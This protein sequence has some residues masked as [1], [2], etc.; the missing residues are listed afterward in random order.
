MAKKPFQRA[1]SVGLSLAL[2]AGMVAPALAADFTDLQEAINDTTAT[3]G[4]EPTSNGTLISEENGGIYGYGWNEATKD[5]ESKGWDIWA[6]NDGDTRNVQLNED[7]IYDAA[8][9]NS[10][11]L[12]TITISNKKV[13]LDL[14]GN[15]IDGG[16][17]EEVKD[18]VGRV[19][20]EA[21]AG[22]GKSVI[23][24]EKNADVTIS[25][26]DITGGKNKTGGGILSNN[27]N[28]TLENVDVHDNYAN[29]SG[30]GIRFNVDSR[31]EAKENY[32]IMNGGSLYHNTVTGQDNSLGNGGG[33]YIQGYSKGRAVA[34][35]T[36][37]DVHHN[38]GF[39]YAGGI[40]TWG[41]D[42]TL[43]NVDVRDNLVT[44]DKG[45]GAGGILVSSGSHLIMNGGSITDNKCYKGVGGG[46][47]ITDT[48]DVAELHG[49]RITGN[50]T[51]GEGG[52]IYLDAPN[53]PTLILGEGNEIHSNTSS[54]G[55]SDIYAET[56]AIIYGLDRT[57]KVPEGQ[58]FDGWYDGEKKHA[59]ATEAFEEDVNLVG[60]LS[61]AGFDNFTD[62]ASTRIDDPAV[63][64]ASGPVTR[65]Q[66]ID[67]L[68]RHEGEPAPVADSGLFED[69]TEE[70]EFS[71]AMAWAKSVGII[72]AYEDGTF[73]P[74]EL[75]TVGA[76]R[77]I[78]ANF[79]RVFGTNAVAAADLTTLTGDEDE[80]VLN[81]DEVLAEFFGEEY[82][83]AKVEE[84]EAA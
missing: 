22:S 24:M 59:V 29:H 47:W 48:K 30:G 84:D 74:D 50:S 13:D 27:S 12:N 76:V 61:N 5:T 44:A 40:R 7:V 26:G 2:C 23:T 3:E 72:E 45:E 54:A 80:A 6:W 65:A 20:Q 64:L 46:M 70:H 55:A 60:R 57:P 8:P 62:P 83:P 28:L 77:S 1:L 68:W 25:N 41:T 49:V 11:D 39:G 73:E 17:R 35:M 32:F 21:S 67:Y 34:T 37:V 58:Q 75:V 4:A 79:A 42:I 31:K 16:Y 9:E 33:I 71:P 53:D 81:C 63:P 66:F 38:D 43:N 15:T 82:V 36:N 56:G 10:P 14:N 51:E 18:D 78:L 19:T 69:V 52:G